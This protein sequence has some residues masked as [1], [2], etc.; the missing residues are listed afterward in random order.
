MRRATTPGRAGRLPRGSDKRDQVVRF[1]RGMAKAKVWSFAPANQDTALDAAL[2]MAP[3]TGTKEEV[4]SFIQ[5]S[6]SS[7]GPCHAGAGIEEG[8]IWMKGWDDFQKLLLAGSTGS[9]DDPLTFTEP[10]DINEIAD[11]SLVA[12]IFD[13][14]REEIIARP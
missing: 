1:G 11:N 10:I 8:E 5:I 3:D 9:P 14:D 7:T 6:S 13:F 12:E 4:P 2:K